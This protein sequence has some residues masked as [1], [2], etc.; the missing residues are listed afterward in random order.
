M[1]KALL[2]GL[3]LLGLSQSLLASTSSDVVLLNQEIMQ[4]K[5]SLTI[6]LDGLAP[7][8]TYD[9]FCERINA[10]MPENIDVY[11]STDPYD[12]I[13]DDKQLKSK[14]F[15]LLRD[16]YA[17]GYHLNFLLINTE[18]TRTI[19][20]TNLDDTAIVTLRDCVAKVRH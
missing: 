3:T 8:V 15:Q 12:T 10:N 5:Q 11:V 2:L 9:I 1:K 13:L 14:V 16:D 20:M 17:R 19:E 7:H 6:K 4:P 18:Y